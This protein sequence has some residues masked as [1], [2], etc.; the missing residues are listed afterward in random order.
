MPENVL[1]FN[2]MRI[3]SLPYNNFAFARIDAGSDAAQTGRS[4]PAAGSVTPKD[5]QKDA[6]YGGVIV[7]ISAEGK[8]AANKFNASQTGQIQIDTQS[9]G[10]AGIEGVKEC[11][12][13][14]NRK[15]VDDS[16]DPSVSYQSPAH[17]SPG[18]AAGKVMA[19]E[20]EHVT[21]E[22]A[23]ADREDRKIV[24]QTVSL[25]ASICPECGRVYVSG[26]V[27][28]TVTKSGNSN[29]Q[30]DNINNSGENNA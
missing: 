15:Y 4:M 26:G 17:I 2:N 25:S 28:R 16:S 23:R 20:R 9:K 3:G 18:Q 1:Y 11:Q 24:S 12:T 21:N 19:H 7:E 30:P 29:N 8:A 22:Q 10:V 5:P 13:C 6:Y 14:K 27:T